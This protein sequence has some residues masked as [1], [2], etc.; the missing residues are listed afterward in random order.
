MSSAGG[1]GA[2]LN[3]RAPLTAAATSSQILGCV[4]TNLRAHAQ[5]MLA[6]APL[7]TDASGMIVG[8]GSVCVH[9]S[10]GDW[11]LS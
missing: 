2:R 6:C 4:L 3:M 9:L 5:H 7:E 10:L 11:V 1:E 8:L